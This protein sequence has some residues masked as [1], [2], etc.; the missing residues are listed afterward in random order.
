M[1]NDG[2]GTGKSDK[3]AVRWYRKA[4]EQG[5]A[6][7]QCNLGYKYDLGEGVPQSDASA[8]HWYEC[9]KQANPLYFDYSK[10]ISPRHA[11]QGGS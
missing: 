7:A 5:Y 10:R 4:A 6:R 3:L 8:V 9:C 2:R 11:M 1:V